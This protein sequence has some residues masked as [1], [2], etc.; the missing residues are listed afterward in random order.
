MKSEAQAQL[1]QHIDSQYYVSPTDLDEIVFKTMNI[2]IALI[3]ALYL[4]GV[5][6]QLG[7]SRIW[8]AKVDPKG[9]WQP[10]VNVLLPIFATAHGTALT[11]A[12]GLMHLDFGGP[13]RPWTLSFE[14]G[15]FLLL[16]CLNWSKTW[17]TLYAMPYNAEGPHLTHSRTAL[18]TRFASPN[19]F[20]SMVLLGYA[21]PVL[22]GLPLMIFQ[23]RSIDQ[24][25]HAYLSLLETIDS[26]GN[27]SPANTPL[28]TWLFNPAVALK[29]QLLKSGGERTHHYGK[30]FAIMLITIHS[31]SV[32]F[33]LWATQAIL[34]TLFKQVKIHRR[35]ILNRRHVLGLELSTTKSNES[36][37]AKGPGFD[38]LET[39]SLDS[40][41]E[42][43]I[44]EFKSANKIKSSNKGN[45]FNWIDWKFITP[46]LRRGTEVGAELWKSDLI[47]HLDEKD[48]VL[49]SNLEAQYLT[50]RQYTANTM[51]QALLICMISGCYITLGLSYVFNW[52][53]APIRTTYPQLC[54]NQLKYAGMIWTLGGFLLATLTAI[55]AS[56]ELP[57][58]PS[59]QTDVPKTQERPES[60]R[61]EMHLHTERTLPFR[62]HAF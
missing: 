4:F 5:F 56:S 39:A 7:K 24:A 8:V 50:L 3:I 55:V 62:S 11:V 32:F 2:L 13:V 1:I 14:A 17:V 49:Q 9:Y 47:R 37:P 40:R 43:F 29:I 52:Q 46:C 15:S 41:A 21:A 58:D 27:Q 31:I 10:N 18:S 12:L 28:T 6:K 35:C 59:H 36:N 61:F 22:I 34:R 54:L 33:L 25:H 20:N 16:H 51:W 19:L 45:S 30:L 26:L 57:K 42:H 38:K 48:Q 23:H 60:S 53:N 44:V